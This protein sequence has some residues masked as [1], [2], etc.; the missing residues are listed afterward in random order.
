MR[1][2]IKFFFILT[3]P[4]L[5]AFYSWKWI[6]K[7]YKFLNSIWSTWKMQRDATSCREARC[8]SKIFL[9]LDTE[10]AVQ[11]CSEEKVFWK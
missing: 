3:C 2:V 11:S 5:I 6:H 10:A 1:E 7:K 4:A 8:H 9:L